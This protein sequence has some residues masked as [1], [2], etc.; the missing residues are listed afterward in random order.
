MLNPI[1]L[2]NQPKYFHNHLMLQEKNHIANN[3][4]FENKNFHNFSNF[5]D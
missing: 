2:K 5:L 1:S 3:S 4:E